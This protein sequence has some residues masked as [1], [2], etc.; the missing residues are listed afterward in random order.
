MGLEWEYCPAVLIS[1]VALV[2]VTLL[3]VKIPYN[4]E[5]ILPTFYGNQSYTESQFLEG[6]HTMRMSGHPALGAP[7][8]AV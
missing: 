4:V 8:C 7:E 2:K 6:S 1:G 3:Q 5:Q